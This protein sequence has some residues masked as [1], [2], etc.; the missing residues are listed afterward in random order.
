MSRF[1]TLFLILSISL[2]CQRESVA[3]KSESTLYGKEF[4]AFVKQEI[5]RKNVAPFLI[6]VPECEPDASGE[7]V[8]NYVRFAEAIENLGEPPLIDG[9]TAKTRIFD[10]TKKIPPIDYIPKEG[11]LAKISP[12]EFDSLVSSL[13]NRTQ[14]ILTA[15]E[16]AVREP[17]CVRSTNEETTI[18][19]AHAYLWFL[20]Q[21]E[22][23]HRCRQNDWD[24]VARLVELHF[25]FADR[26]LQANGN[27]VVIAGIGCEHEALQNLRMICFNF[28]IPSP[29]HVRF[30]KL[31]SN[32]TPIQE[33][34][35]GNAVNQFRTQAIVLAPLAEQKRFSQVIRTHLI[36]SSSKQRKQKRKEQVEPFA[37]DFERLLEG[38]PKPFDFEATLRLINDLELEQIKN[39]SKPILNRD[40]TIKETL[41]KEVSSWPAQMVLNPLFTV[42]RS[43]RVKEHEPLE[44]S[45]V[46]QFRPELAEIEN[47]FGKLLVFSHRNETGL[48][49]RRLVT[50]RNGAGLVMEIMHF[51]N[52][53]GRFPKSLSEIPH[54]DYLNSS[55]H[56]FRG[57]AFRYSAKKKLLWSIGEDETDQNGVDD[58]TF[59]MEPLIQIEELKAKAIREKVDLKRLEQTSVRPGDTAFPLIP[60][61]VLRA[62][63]K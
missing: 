44:Q 62:S 24:T 59:E 36:R 13:A 50:R 6:N 38:H 49:F 12:Q 52:Q 11:E 19:S 42:L 20:L 60:Q 26:L 31:L 1:L 32:R 29:V 35:T 56:D 22:L 43:L 21:I 8:Q 14:S 23:V 5:V 55:L 7:A 33:V 3:Q 30:M 58:R 16:V 57:F 9:K 18:A 61:T 40:W 47:P 54:E 4:Q 25:Q 46:D 41:E 51:R 28:K 10:L 63:D 48:A 53:H 37:Q 39:F 15:L 2:V 17:L 27:L 34:F 45:T